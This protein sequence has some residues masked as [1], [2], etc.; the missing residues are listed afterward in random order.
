MPWVQYKSVYETPA[1]K[2]KQQL[3]SEFRLTRKAHLLKHT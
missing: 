2:A 3:K 1:V